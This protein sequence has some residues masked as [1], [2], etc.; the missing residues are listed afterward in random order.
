[1]L[2]VPLFVLSSTATRGTARRR[3]RPADR[4]GR[5]GVACCCCPSCRELVVDDGR[6]ARCVP[7][8]R[9]VALVARVA[10]AAV[11]AQQ[12]RARGGTWSWVTP[13]WR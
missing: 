4:R 10:A 2:V 11:A 9:R 5:R 3:A 13:A 12:P 6:R 8:L 7:A 1:V